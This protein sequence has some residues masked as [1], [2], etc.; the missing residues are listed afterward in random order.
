MRKLNFSF[1]KNVVVT[2][3]LAS[4]LATGSAFATSNTPIAPNQ[5][6]L[7]AIG[8]MLPD[9]GEIITAELTLAEYLK[10]FTFLTEQEKQQLLATEKAAKPIYDE[11]DQLMKKSEEIAAPIWKDHEALQKEI[12]TIWGSEE[13]L[14]TKLSENASEDQLAKEDFKDFIR[15]SKALTSAEKDRLLALE[16]R[17]APL[18]AKSDAFDQKVED[19]TKDI[20]QKMDTLFEKIDKLGQADTAIWEKIDAHENTPVIKG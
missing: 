14:W 18:Y 8:N 12:D 11:I 5:E 20:H 17:L 13:A 3:L 16:D 2:G 9:E 1:T 15:S 7:P 10:P 6:R 19:A 4:I